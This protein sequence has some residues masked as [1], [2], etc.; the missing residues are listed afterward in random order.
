MPTL[1]GIMERVQGS[2]HPPGEEEREH[3]CIDVR[4]LLDVHSRVRTD[5]YA[6]SGLS[7]LSEYPSR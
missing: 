5:A 3:V 2:L 6:Y 1:Q 7:M 4:F